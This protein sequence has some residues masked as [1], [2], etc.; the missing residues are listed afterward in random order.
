M[1][2]V[3][4]VGNTNIVLGVYDGETL[5]YHWRVSTDK[6]RTSDE[7]GML[8]HSLFAFRGLSMRDIKAVAISSVVPPLIVPLT[9]MCQRYFFVDPLLVGPGVKTGNSYKI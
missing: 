6:Q 2:L 5:L 9:R 1:L 4:D 3:F 8:I 7:Y